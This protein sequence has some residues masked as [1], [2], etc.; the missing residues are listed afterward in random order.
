M[1][2]ISLFTV[3]SPLRA[4]ESPL[5]EVSEI[6]TK[7][8]TSTTKVQKPSAIHITTKKA[9]TTVA[10]TTTV[11]YKGYTDDDL[12]CLAVVIFQEA[13]GS[14][15]SIKLMVGNVV[16]NRVAWKAYYPDTIRGV[17]TQSSQYGRLHWTG[18][19][20]PSRASNAR[21]KKYVQQS[22]D[23][24]QRLLEGERVLPANVIY[25]AEFEQ[26]SGIYKHVSGFY[27]CYA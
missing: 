18:V 14:S 5:L 21:E 3:M 1:A 22:Y 9:S 20:F 27:F 10:V 26:G 8:T 23:V 13:G 12:F 4:G 11:K 2:I 24:A 25:Q 17:V 19:K 6:S 16:L 7:T 15:E